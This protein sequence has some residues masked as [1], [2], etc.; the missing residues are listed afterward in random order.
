M[1]FFPQIPIILIVLAVS[2]RW[3]YT[4]L[5]LNL[6]AVAAYMPQVWCFFFQIDLIGRCKTNGGTVFFSGTTHQYNSSHPAK[7]CKLLVVVLFFEKYKYTTQKS[8]RFSQ[9]SWFSN[10]M[11]NIHTHFSI[12]CF[13]FIP[14]QYVIGIASYTGWGEM[15]CCGSVRQVKKGRRSIQHP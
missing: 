3:R 13:C 9:S 6:A 12:K 7:L 2:T 1:F 14:Q 15:N 4:L 11:Q 8:W 10:F 5:Y